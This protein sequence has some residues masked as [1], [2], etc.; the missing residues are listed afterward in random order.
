[1]LSLHSASEI[2]GIRRFC[3]HIDRQCL[4][5]GRR[6][7]LPYVPIISQPGLIYGKLFADFGQ[8]AKTKVPKEHG[9]FPLHAREVGIVSQPGTK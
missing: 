3:R 9:Q 8:G 6:K 2:M 5:P 1:M 4:S 7:F